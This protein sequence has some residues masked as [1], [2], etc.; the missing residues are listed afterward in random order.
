MMFITPMPPTRR[1]TED[2]AMANES[3][4]HR[5]AVELFDDAVRGLQDRNRLPGCISMTADA[6]ERLR[7]D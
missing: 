2:K 1:P 7:P 3:E 4:I 6:A 5:D